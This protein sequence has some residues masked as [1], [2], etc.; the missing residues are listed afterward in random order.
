MV[1]KI[2]LLL[3]LVSV[4]LWARAT[5]SNL[6]EVIAALNRPFQD[7]TPVAEQ[8][9]NF[10]ADFV[11]RSHIAS[12]DK[13]QQ[14]NGVVFFH[15]RPSTTAAGSRVQFRWNYQQPEKQQIISDG[16]TLWYYLPDNKQVVE[17]DLTH[18]DP[19]QNPL[20]FLNNLGFLEEHFRVSWS[21]TKRDEK[22]N[23]RL[24]LAPHQQTPLIRE[25]DVVVA[26]EAVS[27]WSENHRSGDVFPVLMTA[28]TDQ[29]GNR[30]TIMFRQAQTNQDFD[31][32]LFTFQ[33]PADVD[34][35]T[36]EQLGY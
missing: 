1:R 29:Q 34:I 32:G 28:V 21:D 2:L 35:V 14:G 4:P 30:T 6:D 27:V 23:Y 26:A 11:Q 18:L 12:I 22:G 33:K 9:Q 8:I 17:S 10:Q 24:R 36:A 5:E 31:P 20:I 7:Q 13:T 3:L 16:R 15:F 25:M 19:K